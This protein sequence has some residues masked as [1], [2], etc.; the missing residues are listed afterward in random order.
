MLIG[1]VA[2]VFG[3][4]SDW[5]VMEKCVEQ[6]RAFGEDP[7]VEVMSAHRNP[8]RVRAF[9]NAAEE[10]GV[11]VIIA[12]AG[13]SNA[14]AGAIAAN[15]CLPVIGVPMVSGSMQGMDA[16]L[17]TVQMPSGVPVACVSLGEPGAKNAALLA[18]QIIARHD[19]KLAAAYRNFRADQA[20][21]VEAKNAALQERFR[22]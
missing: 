20:K 12:A 13:M 17:S 14:L 4:D 11:E 18:I 8:D 6:L 15:T 21:R 7:H 9:A 3:S 2:V 22:Q 5:K 1:R 19:E 16:L 10:N